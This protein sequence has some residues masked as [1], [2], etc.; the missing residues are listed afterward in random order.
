MSYFSKYFYNNRF[1]HADDNERNKMI[2]KFA[3]MVIDDNISGFGTIKKNGSK[4]NIRECLNN[5]NN[6][7]FFD[8]K[9]QKSEKCDFDTY[10]L[11]TL[12]DEFLVSKSNK[13]KDENYPYV[14]GCLKGDGQGDVPNNL[15]FNISHGI[16]KISLQRPNSLEKKLINNG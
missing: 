9:Y 13:I 6:C 16:Y 8:T 15:K 3:M 5:G 4:T 11:F 1:T 10:G 7:S 2:D 12:Y 14:V